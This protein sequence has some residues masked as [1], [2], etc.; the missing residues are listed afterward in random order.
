MYSGKT[1]ETRSRVRRF[2]AEKRPG[3]D[4]K[5]T[6]RAIARKI[7]QCCYMAG[8]VK[9]LAKKSDKRNFIT[10]ITEGGPFPHYLGR[11][12]RGRL[13]TRGTNK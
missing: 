10:D 9:A 11:N 8:E 5:K 7:G 3:C 12:V 13:E 6:N 4:D 2:I 1:R